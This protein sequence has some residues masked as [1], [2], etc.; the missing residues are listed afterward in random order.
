M[1]DDRYQSFL[2][3]PAIV[4][5]RAARGIVKIYKW[6]L[7][8]TCVAVVVFVLWQIAMVMNDVSHHRTPAILRNQHH[9]QASPGTPNFPRR[10]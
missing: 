4:P 9:R 2:A 8:L 10:S 3:V 1:R 6:L 5:A 7:I